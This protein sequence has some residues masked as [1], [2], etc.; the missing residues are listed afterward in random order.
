MASSGRK[1]TTTGTEAAVRNARI[2]ATAIPPLDR[3]R[4]STAQKNAAMR[5]HA[6]FTPLATSSS[7]AMGSSTSAAA[8]VRRSRRNLMK[9]ALAWYTNRAQQAAMTVP[10]TA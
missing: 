4:H 8:R 1:A 3:G 10:V 2:A 5:Y 6:V 7:G 9:P